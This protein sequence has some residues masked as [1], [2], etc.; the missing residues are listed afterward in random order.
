ME[1]RWCCSVC[2]ALNWWHELD[3][4]ACWKGTRFEAIAPP[5]NLGINVRVERTGEGVKLSPVIDGHETGGG[6]MIPRRPMRD[7]STA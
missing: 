3:C 2:T 1:E 4:T 5:P 6:S 7:N